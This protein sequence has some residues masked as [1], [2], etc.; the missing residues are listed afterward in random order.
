MDRKNMKTKRVL[1]AVC[2]WLVAQAMMAQ[3]TYTNPVYNSDFPD[4][5]VQRAQDGYFYAY[6]TG[7]RGLRSKDLVKWEKLSNVIARPTWNDSTYIDASG[8]KTT[9]YY[10]FWACDVNYVDG[11]Y[12][13]YYACALWGNGSRTGIGVATGTSPDKFTDRGR[14]FRSTEIGVNNSIDPCYV[15]QKDKK[16]L[17]WGSFNDIYISELS[18]NGLKIKDFKKK[19]KIGGGA[20]EGVM[21]YKRGGYYYMFASIG[22]CCNGV[23]STYRTVVGRATSIM[24]PYVNKQGGTMFDNNYTTII[25]GNSQWKGTGHNS[26]IVTD[27]NGDDWLLYHAYDAK[28]DSKGRVM[29]LDKITW[30]RDG[31]PSVNNG[32]PST[33]AQQGPVFYK[34]D[35]ANKTY[36]FQN[37]DV[38]KSAFKGWTVEASDDCKPVSG[39]GTVFYPLGYVKGGAASF[40]IY[41]SRTGMPDGL[42]EL[43][44]N[45]FDTGNSVEAYV[46]DV[47]TPIHNDDQTGTVPASDNTISN[48]FQRGSFQR[49]FYGLVTGGTLR[50]GFRTSQPMEASDRFYMANAQVIYREKNATALTAVLNSYETRAGEVLQT[51]KP[52]Y[53]GY[54]E[55]LQAYRQAVGG[56]DDTETRYALLQ[57]IA[58]TLD[59]IGQSIQLYD[60]LSRQVSLMTAE[61]ERAQAGGFSSAEAEAVL[62]EAQAALQTQSYTDKQAA[63]LITRMI[64]STHDMSYSYQQGDGTAE[65]PYLISRP[66]QLDH[67]RDVLVREQ[68]VYFAMTD[69]V[70]MTGYRWE[71][72]NGSSSSYRNW[73]N[74]DGRGHIIKN[75]C[76]ESDN[77]YPS[78]FGTLCGE[79][80]NVGF[81]DADVTSTASG[82]GILS[83]YMGHSSFKDA[84]GNLLPVIVENCYF[85]GRIASKG[86][87]GVLGGTLNNSPVTIR[88]VYTRVDIT[89]TGMSGNYCGGLVGRVRT[90]LTIQNCYSAGSIEGPIA[91][92]IAAGGQ[93]S[94]TPPSLYQNVIAWNPA[95]AGASATP[96]AFTAEGDQL[97]GTYTFSGMALN[98]EAVLTDGLSHAELQ[99]IA[100]QWGA[101]W[102][103]DPSAGNGYPI[104]QWQYDRGDYP[105]LC[106]FPLPGIIENGKVKAG[107]A[108]E[109]IY[110]LT[111]RR[112]SPAGKAALKGIY[113]IDGKKTIIR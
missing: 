3:T 64:Q 7:Q 68:M 53:S 6:A 112:I 71:Q 40:D 66:E 10:S 63:D 46:G 110:D 27:D 101:P 99:Q 69:D 95:V 61:V 60:S 8:K 55:S 96:F 23:N 74:F 11:R 4:P 72:L 54:R 104:L 33:T 70:D 34:G 92:P 48:T 28:D 45:T 89:G 26:E 18:E 29:L 47:A 5:S 39:A 49:S 77:G 42:Y 41:Q 73:I 109:E 50:F 17:V 22:S 12:L 83:G 1:S 20:F 98:G 59:S 88:N 80:R 30:S 91:A 2:G 106:G 13:M 82:G 81:V 67:M 76:P 111:G 94:S 15:E 86:Y 37:M 105:L 19:T 57:K 100:A 38:D 90:A 25:Q 9:D 97:Q 108:P 75:L 56:T 31:W 93:N 62:K 58:G 51:Q 87:V 107:N 32:S 16:Y 85:T 52:F 103:A 35:G 102:Y 113:I 36:L 79:C 78:F 14:L 44:V 24:G 84:E 65:N 21:I 43:R